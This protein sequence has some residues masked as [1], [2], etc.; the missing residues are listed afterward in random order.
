MQAR[1]PAAD[2]R[3]KVSSPPGRRLGSV[4]SAVFGVIYVEVNAGSLP[5]TMVL[6]LRVLGAAVFLLVL[7][8]LWPDGSQQPTPLDRRVVGFGSRYWLIVAL[9]AAGIVVGSAALRAVGL[10]SATVAWV[11]IVVGVHFL[12]LA[13]AWRLSLLR[14]LGTAIA[15]CGAVAI[16]AAAA[17]AGTAWVAGIGGVLPGGLLL[18]AAT[19]GPRASVDHAHLGS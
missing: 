10:G 15:L 8:R 12:A 4:I 13:A 9:E 18:R 2:A 19:R 14:R 17:G 6:M 5:A 7:I 1:P 16:V 3:L 11:S